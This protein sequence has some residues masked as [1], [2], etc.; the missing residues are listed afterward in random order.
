MMCE[1]ERS[2][3]EGLADGAVN[4]PPRPPHRILV[5]EDDGD[6]RHLNTAVLTQSGYHV[7]AAKDGAEAWATLQVK[8][9]DLL[10]T[11]NEMPKV[12]G[13]ELLKNLQAAQMPLPAIMATGS[14]PQDEFV[15]H[16]QIKPAVLL[17]KPYTIEELLKKVK[18]V[19]QNI[20]GGNV[21][22]Y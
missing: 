17:L 19:L 5:V 16:P 9:Y 10:V 1:K 11:D 18:E 14:L 13:I 15:R 4:A 3:T 2:Q 22:S 8:T 6:I 12:T 21:Q 20:D 7:D